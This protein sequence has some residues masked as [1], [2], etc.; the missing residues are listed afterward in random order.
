MES[1]RSNI[2]DVLLV[3]LS[4]TLLILAFPKTD[5]WLLSWAALVPFFYALERKGPRGCF[6]LSFI[7]GVIFFA[8]TLY[9][10]IYVTKL[11]AALLV[12]YCSVY[13]GL[14]GCAY[15]FVRGKA[16]GIKMIFLPGFWVTLE[17]ARAHLMSGFGWASLGHSQYKNLIFVQLADGT[18]VFGISFL[19]VLVNVVVKGWV[20]QLMKKKKDDQLGKVSLILAAFL[21]LVGGYGTYRL[22][23]KTDGETVSIAVVQGNIPQEL[24]WHEPYWPDIMEKYK[25]LTRQAALDAPDLIIWPETSFPGY[26]GEHDELFDQLKEFI[27]EL[28]IPLLLGSVVREDDRYYNSA[29]LISKEGKMDQRYDKL[30]LV[31]FGEYIPFRKFFP[32][33]SQIVPIADFSK[34]TQFTL[35]AVPTKPQRHLAVLICFEDSMGY[36]S[37]LF[38]QQG[39]QLLV[40]ITNDAWFGD[41]KAAFMHLQ[42]A[43]F[44]SVENRRELVRSTNT[45]VSCFIDA[46]GRIKRFVQD[47]N[48]KQTYVLGHATE[49]A[50]LHHSKTFYSHFGDIFSYFCFGAVL[51]VFFLE[52]LSLKSVSARNSI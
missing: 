2:K 27:A 15:H 25:I 13:F 42:T 48:G 32:F 35:F 34:G 4:S 47:K 51:G 12:L 8:G 49:K 11:G 14:F 39:A 37:R 19:V 10:F 22:Q 20:D 23:E 18:G 29:V 41:T 17:F 43:V 6:I 31:P 52:R 26:V 45:G 40:N 33:L 5:W 28:G 3:I 9:W 44:R 36:L 21:L 38:V 46:K 30:H 7:A 24:K 16:L 1:I 50:R